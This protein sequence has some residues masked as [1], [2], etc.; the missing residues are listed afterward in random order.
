MRKLVNLLLGETFLIRILMVFLILVTILSIGGSY[1]VLGYNVPIWSILTALYVLTRFVNIQNH[2]HKVS[3]TLSKEEMQKRRILKAKLEQLKSFQGKDEKT[4]F[5]MSPEEIITMLI[6]GIL[7]LVSIIFIAND[8]AHFASHKD[9]L[10]DHS[11]FLGFGITIYSMIVA[12]AKERLNFAII[13]L[14]EED[15]A[16]SHKQ[17]IRSQKIRRQRQYAKPRYRNRRFNK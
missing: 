14:T 2:R 3:L 13:R 17:K 4:F 6:A 12:Q 7:M 9:K 15:E 5:F 1:S 16:F 10:A 8:F 11:S